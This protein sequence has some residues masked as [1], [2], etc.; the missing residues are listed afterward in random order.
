[1]PSFSAFFLDGRGA[2]KGEKRMK[3]RTASLGIAILAF[4]CLSAVAVVI[5]RS[6]HERDLLESKNACEEIMNNL[7]ASLRDHDDF[8]SA[9]ELYPDL[10]SKIQALGVY[11]PDGSKVYS[12]GTAPG[13]YAQASSIQL[14]DSPTRYYLENSKNDSFIFLLHPFRFV[15]PRPPRER[16]DGSPPPRPEDAEL[17]RDAGAGTQRTP[18]EHP[19]FFETLRKAEIVYLE[20]RQPV[21]WREQRFR[22][23]LFPV[24]ELLVAALVF[25]MR[26]LILRNAE[27]RVRIEE[28]RNL[29]VLGTAASTL[30]HEI[31]N[32]LLSIRLQS[33][34]LE[35]LCPED[36]KRELSIINDEVDRLSAL[37]YR[38]NDYLR[39]PLG[40]A[41]VLDVAEA[42][43][44][45]SRRLIGRD[46]SSRLSDGPFLASVD[47][48]RFRSIIENLVRNAMESGGPQDGL[49]IEIGKSSGSVTID[50]LDRGPGIPAESRERAF[51]PFFTTKS[52]GTGIGLAISRRFAEA[53]G[54][55][56]TIGERQGGGCLVR[57]TLPEQTTGE[58]A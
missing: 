21:Y 56:I 30:A 8:G 42:A 16:S 33:S 3:A 29:V 10:R 25:F 36:G 1:M 24:V 23:V 6:M 9:I 51:D 57:I 5:F 19:F 13:S 55:K 14:G 54:G 17:G 45:T 15:P 53:A 2:M 38:V 49:A 18:T 22:Q 11:A 50:V 44:E 20:I 26:F 52:R 48:D 12:W 34:I 41:V 46:A 7:F 37:T 27:Y 40:K 58:V 31:K 47:P 39:E 4:A 35:R 28:Q 32:P 43:A